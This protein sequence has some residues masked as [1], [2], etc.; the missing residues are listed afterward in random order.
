MPLLQVTSTWF[1]SIVLLTESECDVLLPQCSL[2]NNLVV[3]VKNV[4]IALSRNSTSE[5]RDVTWQMG[6]HSVTCHPTQVN[7][8]RLN[9]NQAGR[10]SIYLPR[11]DGKAELTQMVG[12]IRRWFRSTCLQ[13]GQVQSNYVDRSQ[14]INHYNK[15]PPVVDA[16]ARLRS[17]GQKLIKKL[18]TKSFTKIFQLDYHNKIYNYLQFIVVLNCQPLDLFVEAWN[19]CS[20]VIVNCCG[21]TSMNCDH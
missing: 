18:P 16:E 10:Y 7:A 2:L 5:L 20:N 12:Y 14:R 4:C 11:R 9:P 6:S 19:L 8:P 15:Q 1:G 17:D 13:M 21:I 3:P